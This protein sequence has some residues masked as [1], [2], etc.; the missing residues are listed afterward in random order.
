MHA[1]GR[2][3]NEMEYPGTSLHLF[4]FPMLCVMAAHCLFILLL[5][6]LIFS[7]VGMLI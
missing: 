2:G 6:L 3:W 1:D 4:T 7:S 5:I